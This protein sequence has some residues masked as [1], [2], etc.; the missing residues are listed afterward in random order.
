M[1]PDSLMLSW[2]CL[3]PISWSQQIRSSPGND[4]IGD[5]EG[6]YL[7]ATCRAKADCEL[8]LPNKA[9][10][11][12]FE[13]PISVSCGRN[14]ER[15]RQHFKLTNDAIGFLGF[16]GNNVSGFEVSGSFDLNDEN[17]TALW[18]QVLNGKYTSCQFILGVLP[19]QDD[20]WTAD[21]LSILSASIDIHRTNTS[22]DAASVA[23]MAKLADLEKAFVKGSFLI[24]T[25][26]IIACAVLYF[27]RH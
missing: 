4:W 25:A 23:I 11:R 21:T 6:G 18:D 17:F 7:V 8:M 14:L 20:V 5:D 19:V 16:G 13:I 3:E 24:V 10:L 9:M 27:A 22:I 12:D 15:K 2:I 26:I 1:L